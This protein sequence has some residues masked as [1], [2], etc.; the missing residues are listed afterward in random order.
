M[1]TTFR[2]LTITPKP[3]LT[4]FDADKSSS[5]SVIR[6][7]EKLHDSDPY[8]ALAYFYFSFSD[9][10]KQNT[11]NMLRS[12]IVQ[13]C[14]GRPDTPK[15][16]LDLHTYEEKNLKP[17]IEKLREVLRASM[18]D[19]EHVY[20]IIDALDE[21]PLDSGEREKLLKVLR[22]LRKW[23]LANLHVLYTSRPEPDI[24]T[25]LEPMFSEPNSSM[26]DLGERHKEITKD[27]GTYIDDKLISS[28]DFETWPPDIKQEVKE[29]LAEKA[30]GMYDESN[31]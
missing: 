21:C 20:L 18:H 19:F 9:T 29:A 2:C 1:R 11:E 12:L 24:T 10:A 15:S 17:G 5:S 25:N 3:F 31:T 28:S 14:G 22:H 30:N 16:L 8:T 6:Y 27:I 23:S 13:L 4:P 7:L 26:V